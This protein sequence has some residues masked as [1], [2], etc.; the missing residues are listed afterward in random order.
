[1]KVIKRQRTTRETT[2]RKKMQRGKKRENKQTTLNILQWNADGI[3]TKKTELMKTLHDKDIDLAL[4]RETK[5]SKETNFDVNGYRVIRQDRETWMRG[6]RVEE[7]KTPGGG[8]LILVKDGLP[9][10]ERKP[11]S[12]HPDDNTTEI[13]TVEVD[14]GRKK[15]RVTNVYIPP[16]R[17]CR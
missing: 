11:H 1:M 8:I 7:N 14:K 5:L 6:C 4:I 12:R 9:H 16:I 2:N 13:Q 15:L 3:R 17:Q 10:I